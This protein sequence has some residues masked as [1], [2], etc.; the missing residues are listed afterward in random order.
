M[1]SLE[2][3]ADAIDGDV[4]RRSVAHQKKSAAL[5]AALHGAHDREFHRVVEAA[6]M[7]V[8]ALVEE[9]FENEQHGVL[10]FAAGRYVGED[11]GQRADTR[12]YFGGHLADSR[13]MKSVDVGTVGDEEANETHV[14]VSRWKIDIW[15]MSLLNPN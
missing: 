15:E 3:D 14:V 9:V 8:G 4:G 10:V 5:E 2:Q 7:N 13:R 12:S 11:A 6:P 1:A